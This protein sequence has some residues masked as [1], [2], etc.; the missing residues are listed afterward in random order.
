M[1]LQLCSFHSLYVL[2][3]MMQ[4]Q[5]PVRCLRTE[6]WDLHDVLGGLSPCNSLSDVYLYTLLNQPSARSCWHSTTLV[7]GEDQNIVTDQRSKHKYLWTVIQKPKQGLKCGKSGTYMS[8]MSIFSWELRL[9]SETYLSVFIRFCKIA[10]IID[11]FFAVILLLR[12]L[13]YTTRPLTIIPIRAKVTWKQS[14]SL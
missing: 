8:T 14:T 13:Q 11:T 1:L 5:L 9:T 12:F 2:V 6:S 3:V 7:E 10:K 4:L